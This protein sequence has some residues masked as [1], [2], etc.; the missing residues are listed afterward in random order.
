MP[1]EKSD[2]A[3]H[4][5]SVY[6]SGEPQPRSSPQLSE[7]LQR[8]HALV[9]HVFRLFRVDL[10]RGEIAFVHHKLKTEL[11]KT[12]TV[13]SIAVLLGIASASA[14]EKHEHAPGPGL[15][16][17]PPEYVHVL[18]NPLPV[19][20]LAIGILALGAALLARSKP[21]RAIALGII[22]VSSASD[23]AVAHYGKNAY[24]GI[25]EKSDEA[26]Q[27]WLDEHMDRAEKFVYVFYAT[28]LLGIAALI[29]QKKFPKA[30]T[31]LTVITLVASVASLGIG[32]WISKAGGQIRHPE[33]RTGSA[34]PAKGAPH[35]H[36]ASKPS[37]ETMQPDK[38][39]HADAGEGHK[40][41][42]AD[43]QSAEKPAAE[44]PQLPDTLEG[45]W[46]HI[47]EHH[48]ELE[49]AITGK[50]FSE[51]QTHVQHLSAL[52]KRLVELS[53]ADHK[54]AVENGVNK[55][56]QPL[57]ELKQSAETGSELVLKTN[58]DA[59]VK[60]LNELEE[61]MKKQ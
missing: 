47:H 1:S 9:I 36:D 61:Q 13:I 8:R 23:W 5:R 21:A 29:S 10:R 41:G 32:G 16:G 35:E 57:A 26:G 17:Q 14:H 43:K 11:M 15:F 49:T 38:M 56:N 55:I 19:Y 46:K 60:S 40:H 33:F 6:C 52:T 20:G 37:H 22:I 7:S 24:A 25:R 50:K 2:L 44:K 58:F 34:P 48:A 4:A 45:V 27:K 30:A 31:G 18:L 54:T 28:A 59:F 42:A 12:L 51:V 39:Q 53:H 3:L